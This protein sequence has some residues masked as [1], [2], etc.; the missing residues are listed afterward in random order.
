MKSLLRIFTILTPKQMRKCVLLI[1]LM[2]FSAVL[3]TLGIGAL[4]PLIQVI[5]DPKVLERHARIAFI[6]GH[7]GIKSHGALI[8]FCSFGLIV[9]YALKNAYMVFQMRM[10]FR[11]ATNLQKTFVSRL[12]SLYL[13]KPYTFHI[14]TN[15][16]KSGL[17]AVGYGDAI[18][19]GVLWQTLAMITE[20]LTVI[21]IWL[22][23]FKLNWMIALF[24]IVTIC[25]L[26]IYILKTFKR[27]LVQQSNLQKAAAIDYGKWMTQGFRAIKETKVMRIERYIVDKFK[28]SYF[29][30]ADSN[31]YYKFLS[32]VPRSIVELVGMG[33]ILLVIIGAMLIRMRPDHIVP[34]LGVLAVAATRLMPCATRIM[35]SFNSIKFNLPRFED[36]YDDLLVV[37]RGEDAVERGIV[38]KEAPPMPFEHEIVVDNLSFRYPDTKTDV[39]NGVSFTIPKSAF[40]GI[41]GPSGAGKT[42]FVDILLGLL[43]PTGGHITVD[44]SDIYGNIAGWLSNI[45]YVPQGIYLIDGSIR[46]NVALGVKEEDIDYELLEKSLRMAEIWDFVQAQ[47]KGLK[48]SVGEMGSHLSGG[49]KQR[50]GIARALYRKP[51]VLVLDEATSALDNDTERNITN[52]ILKLKNSITIISIA[53]RLST[54]ADCDFKIRLENGKASMEKGDK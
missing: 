23:I 37:R 29:K 43:P 14:N 13:Y 21:V 20:L 51:K 18:F 28:V 24:I 6:I 22:L 5:S 42:T 1:V 47:P 4:Y 53:H 36:V 54:L 3:E 46:D 48:S 32:I 33:G 52:T 8:I 9:F 12:F 25:P 34:T 49:Q 38:E 40:V 27:L 11:F 39:L 44:G 31:E 15:S 35:A 10:Q 26:G 30:F 50:I 7:L 41:V 2:L 16:A 19:S 45:A 17:M